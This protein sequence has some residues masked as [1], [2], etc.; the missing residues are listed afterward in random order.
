M[1]AAQ[2]L[3]ALLEPRPAHGYMLKRAYDEHFARVKPLP[4]GQVYA[5]LSR[6]ERDGLARLAG[7]ELAEGP[8]RRIYAITPKGVTRVEHWLAEPEDPTTFAVSALFAKTT[9]ALLSGR[10]P[11]GVLDAQREVHLDRMRLLTRLRRSAAGTELLAVTY[12][13]A[14]LDADLRWIDESGQ[15]LAADRA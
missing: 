2:M 4:Y 10:S 12:E 14:H 5:S 15:R 8:E 9:I 11:A 13:I 3:L 6:F 7:T 1:S